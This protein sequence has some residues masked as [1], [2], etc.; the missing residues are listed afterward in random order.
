[1]T[2]TA[3]LRELL[4]MCA[5]ALLSACADTR[6]QSDQRAAEYMACLDRVSDSDAC[7]RAATALHP[8][9]AALKDKSHA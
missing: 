4:G 9:H 5:L 3:K 8:D 6:P 1:M 7:L 2:D